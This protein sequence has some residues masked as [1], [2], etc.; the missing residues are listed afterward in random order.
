[1]TV[2]SYKGKVVKSTGSWYLIKTEDNQLIESRI[3]GKF[4][5]K[6][7]RTTNPVAVGDHVDYVLEENGN[8]I[9]TRLHERHNYII[10][11]STNLSKKYHIIASNIDQL[12][13]I[14]SIV[15]PNIAFGLIDRLLV[16][17]EA[18]GIDASIVFNK[19]D[20]VHG[21]K[22]AE[23]QLD[24]ARNIYE[25]IGYKCIITSVKN[26]FGVNDLKEALKGKTSLVSGHSGVGKSSIINAVDPQL[27][28]KTSEVSE[29]NE[30]GKHTTTFA[31][32]H[33]LI[34]LGNNS[35][36]IDTPGI[37]S[38]G[39]IDFEPEHLGHYFPEIK[40]KM[41]ECK[42]NNCVHINEPKCAVKN[43]LEEG[44][45]HPYRYAHYVAMF[46]DDDLKKEWEL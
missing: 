46:E 35:E 18:Y 9:I 20:L 2:K 10:R 3:K 19:F 6:N 27:D 37:R 13:V 11:K 42:F 36:I 4:R 14:S 17:A 29:F 23:E 44:E 45:I 21:S 28:L 5:L 34:E 12:V 43:A 41:A 22:K 16:T 24:L 39:I 8:G 26:K 33:R 30:K 1:M 25:S 40:A 38:F 31:E 32:L 7:T 15:Q